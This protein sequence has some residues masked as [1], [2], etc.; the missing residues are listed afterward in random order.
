MVINQ[1]K[2]ILIPQQRMEFLGFVVDATTL[3]LVFPAEKLRKIQQLAL[4]LLCQQTVSIRELARFVGK[5]SASQRAVWQA[6]LHYRAL[7]FLINFVV[8][9]DQSQQEGSDAKFNTNLR[10]TKEAKADLMWW[11][12]LDRKIPWQSPLY[13]KLPSMTIES[14]TSNMGWKARQGEHQ[15]GGRWSTEEASHHINYRELL[16]AFLA[17]QCFAKHSHNATIL[18]RLDSVTA[19]TYIN[20]LGGTHSLPLCQLA[21]TIWDWCIQ[22]EIFLLAEHLPG[23]DNVIADQES[24]SMKD[25]CD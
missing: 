24:R 9:T 13:P 15:T 3:H 10:L 4:H 21:L 14:D 23:K 8:L 12:S 22:R 7:Q 6:P 17:L 5:T 19:V 11:S 18:M 16:A 20:K 25:R 1:K 2:S